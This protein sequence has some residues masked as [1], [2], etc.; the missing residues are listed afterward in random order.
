MKRGLGMSA[1]VPG[2][3][4]AETEA[5][6]IELVK[7]MRVATNPEE[8]VKL[9]AEWLRSSHDKKMQQVGDH[10]IARLAETVRTASTEEEA[11][12]ELRR[13]FPAM[14]GDRLYGEISDMAEGKGKGRE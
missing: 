3:W 6:Q 9:L 7:N 1:E 2:R 4:E 12:D 13:E 14:V 5:R 10:D 11:V 8:S